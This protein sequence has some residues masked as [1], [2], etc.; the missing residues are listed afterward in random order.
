ML[1][2]KPI[3]AMY[4]DVKVNNNSF[5]DSIIT[6]QLIDQLGHRVDCAASTRIITADEATKTPI[7]EID[8]FPIEVNGII[9]P[10]KV[11]VMETTQYQALVVPAMCKHFKLS[12]NMLA[13]FIELKKK[14]LPKKSITNLD[15]ERKK[16]KKEEE[17]K[18]STSHYLYLYTIYLLSITPNNISE[19]G[20]TYNELC[21]YTILISNWIQKKTP[22][23]ATWRKAV[24][25]L[26]D[27]SHDNNKIWQITFAKIEETSSEEIKTIKNNSPEPIKLDWSLNLDIILEPMDPEQ[28]HKH[29]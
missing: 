20:E 12:N 18:I 13:P 23:K 27:C 8:N 11:L 29:Y 3:T 9:I 17:K 15:L 7:G 1:K 4:T 10:I 2:E 22:I 16:K 28:F 26:N 14:N 25:Y 5:T 19:Q 6:Q 24:K 21:Q